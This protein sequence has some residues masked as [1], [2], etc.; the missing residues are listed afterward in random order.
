[1]DSKLKIEKI[2]PCFR[3]VGMK[4]SI[5]GL[6]GESAAYYPQKRNRVVHNQILVLLILIYS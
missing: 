4:T 2:K 5:L 1:M 3:T 6:N